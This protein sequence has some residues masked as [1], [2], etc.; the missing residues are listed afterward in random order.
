MLFGTAFC[1]ACLFSQAVFRESKKRKL[2]LA[3]KKDIYLQLYSVR[4]DIKPTMP[5]P[6]PRWLK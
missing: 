1:A 5:R 3:V 2:R 4:D 6:L